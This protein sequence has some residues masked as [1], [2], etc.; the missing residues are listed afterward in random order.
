MLESLLA[1]SES[2]LITMYGWFH[3]VRLQLY[4][5]PLVFILTDTNLRIICHDSSKY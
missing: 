2:P 3:T 1:N 4:L 5:Y